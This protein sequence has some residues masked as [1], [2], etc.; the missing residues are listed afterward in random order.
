MAQVTNVPKY[1]AINEPTT[2]AASLRDSVLSLK[3]TTEMLT[4]QRGDPAV[5]AITWQD[6]VN[7]GL[8]S[9]SD[10]PKIASKK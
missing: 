7:L 6:L 10:I 1:P 9:A 8:I 5:S 2:D 4:R 3:E